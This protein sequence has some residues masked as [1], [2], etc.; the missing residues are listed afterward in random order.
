MEYSDFGTWLIHAFLFWIVFKIGQA[1]GTI[2]ALRELGNKKLATSATIIRQRPI[3]EIEEI[4]GIYYA[5]D[6]HDF[7]AQGN[8][9]DDLGR[10]IAD[11]YPD[12]YR[13]AQVKIKV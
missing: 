11:R 6:G 9:P 12:K 13:T 7:L 1:H 3:I 5:Y 2:Q 4:N 10:R 8:N